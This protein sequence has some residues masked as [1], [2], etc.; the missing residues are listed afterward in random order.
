MKKLFLLA[1]LAVMAVSASAQVEKGFRYGVTGGIS[2]SNVTGDDVDGS[3]MIGYQVG[4]IADYNFNEKLFV[5]TGLG[6]VN[7]GTKDM[8]GGAVEGDF[9]GTYLSLPIHIGYRFN[10]SDNM[11]LNV[12]AGP[13]I[14][15]GLFGSDIEWNDGSEDT[16]YFD[17]GWAER[18]EIGL[19]AKVGV[20]FN[21]LQINL[22]VNYG[23]TKFAEDTD[24]HTMSYTLGLGY[25]F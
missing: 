15:Y 13:E 3:S 6:L 22:G 12:S 17:D 25:M 8:F 20:E 2:M 21:K 10:V 4:V 16:N 1:V 14:A 9:K 7:K 5:G 11:L 18:F 24:A 23:V 19:G